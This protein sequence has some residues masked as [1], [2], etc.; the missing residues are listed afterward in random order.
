[1]SNEN[2][3]DDS[4][5]MSCGMDLAELE[6]GLGLNGDRNMDFLLDIL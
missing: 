2:I 4:Q 6:P 1:M 5:M 3:T